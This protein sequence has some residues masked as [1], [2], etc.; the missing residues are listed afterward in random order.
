[1]SKYPIT[2][3]RAEEL[4][5]LMA[6]LGIIQ[7][8][9]LVLEEKPPILPVKCSR[10]LIA[11]NADLLIVPTIASTA[12]DHDIVEEIMGFSRCDA[13]MV[14]VVHSG[15]GIS[16]VVLDIGIHGP[17]PVWHRKYRPCLLDRALHF[18]PDQ[19]AGGPT[20]KLTKSGL[21]ASVDFHDLDPDWI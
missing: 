1:M 3:Q 14:S 16:R 6:A 19:D 9:D 10:Y 13:L 5:T 15:T 7:I 11:A 12:Q 2:T 17:V 8:A 18:V 20:F 21:I 4:E